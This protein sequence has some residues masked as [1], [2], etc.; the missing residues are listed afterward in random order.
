MHAGITPE[1]PSWSWWELSLG[2]GDCQTRI[3]DVTNSLQH[4]S[5]P[6]VC[7]GINS[8]RYLIFPVNLTGLLLMGFTFHSTWL[9]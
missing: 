7:G 9:H 2:T 1:L 5:L 3:S 6:I 8:L 4:H